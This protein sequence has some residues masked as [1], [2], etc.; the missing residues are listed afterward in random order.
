MSREFSFPVVQEIF[1][2][3]PVPAPSADLGLEIAR[4]ALARQET[5]PVSQRALV[6]A[7][8]VHRP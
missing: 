1:P 5:A 8:L 7:S 6:A 2:P 3:R 4:H